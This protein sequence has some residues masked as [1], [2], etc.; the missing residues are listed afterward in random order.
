MAA[1]GFAKYDEFSEAILQNTGVSVCTRM[2]FGRPQQDEKQKY[3]R[4]AYSGINADQIIE[5]L[6]RLKNFLES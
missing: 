2:H 1:K 3:L 4:L 6:N 5:G